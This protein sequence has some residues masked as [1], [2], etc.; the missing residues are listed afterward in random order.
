[1]RSGDAILPALVVGSTAHGSQANERHRERSATAVIHTPTPAEI[2]RYLSDQRADEI[3]RRSSASCRVTN[4]VWPGAVD[5]DPIVGWLVAYSGNAVGKD[6]RLRAAG[7]ASA[8]PL[9]R[10]L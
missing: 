1:M 10:T 4:A 6:Y 3:R 5:T 9:R 2:E 7:C 8:V